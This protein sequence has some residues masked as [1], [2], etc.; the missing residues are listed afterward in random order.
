MEDMYT[1]GRD[2]G[3]CCGD[4][5]ISPGAPLSRIL[6]CSPARM[7]SE[8]SP[9]CICVC[10]M[11]NSLHRHPLVTDPIS[12]PSPLPRDQGSGA[13]NSN[14]VITWL[15]LLTTN[16]HLYVLSVSLHINRDTTVAVNRSKIA[17][18]SEVCQQWDKDQISIY[19]FLV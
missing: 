16:P 17:R 9:V 18:V 4:S 2:S 6:M 13:E 3:H 19:I 12:S 5:T 10:L 1:Q 11:E 15:V 8:L 14:S 7:L